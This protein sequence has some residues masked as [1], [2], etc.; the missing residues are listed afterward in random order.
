MIS[1]KRKKVLR[2]RKK[3]KSHTWLSEIR[4]PRGGQEPSGPVERLRRAGKICTE[5][6]KK[7]DC[8]LAF[9]L[10]KFTL[11]KSTFFH[12]HAI[13]HK[14]VILDPFL[15]FQWKILSVPNKSLARSSSNNNDHAVNM[16]GNIFKKKLTD[17]SMVSLWTDCRGILSYNLRTIKGIGWFSQISGRSH[18]QCYEWIHFFL[19]ELQ[20]FLILF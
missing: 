9:F 8:L 6:E 13:K 15:L 3:S 1:W 10:F 14:D 12:L 17:R 11:G 16:N 18:G 4:S 5:G 7:P 19:P 20:F 2:Q